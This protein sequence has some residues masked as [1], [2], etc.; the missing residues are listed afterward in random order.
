MAKTTTMTI[1]AKMK[2]RE[3]KT[4]VVPAGPTKDEL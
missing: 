3:V 2:T 1:R 4:A